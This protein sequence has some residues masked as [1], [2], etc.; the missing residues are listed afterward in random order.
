MSEKKFIRREDCDKVKTK[1]FWPHPKIYERAKQI[2]KMLGPDYPL[3]WVINLAIAIFDQ[4]LK[5]EVI[6][7]VNDGESI[8]QI[9]KLKG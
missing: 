2:S 9:F 8:A 5:P 1:L 6:K 7:R 4:L 3:H